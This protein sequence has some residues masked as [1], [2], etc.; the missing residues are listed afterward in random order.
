MDANLMLTTFQD[1]ITVTVLST[2][3]TLATKLSA[4][5]SASARRLVCGQ[6][7][8]PTAR[9]EVSADQVSRG[10]PQTRHNRLILT[11]IC[12]TNKL[13]SEQEKSF[14]LLFLVKFDPKLQQYR[15]LSGGNV[16]SYLL[17]RW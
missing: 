4:M 11:Q 2:P 17:I 14:I 13:L 5:R 12:Q 15:V 16:K 6:G 9:R 1:A 3:V 10:P 8:S 7:Q